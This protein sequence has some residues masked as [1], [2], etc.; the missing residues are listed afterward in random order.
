MLA[1]EYC[2][3]SALKPEDVRAQWKKQY[4][5]EDG[6]MILFS[7]DGCKQCNNTG[8]KG[9]LGI[10]ELLITSAAIKKKIHAKANVAAML[11]TAISE[12]MRTLKQD[13]IEKIFQGLTDWEQIRAI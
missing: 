7:A 10:H 4:G 13:G 11:E 8:Y 12:G 2:F 9:R 1:S 5:I 3:E 6:G